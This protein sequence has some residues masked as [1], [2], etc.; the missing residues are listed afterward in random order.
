MP[1]PQCPNC[2]QP[3]NR[4]LDLAYGYWQ[5][6]DEA[7][8]YVHQTCSDRVDV[9]PWVHDQCMGELRDLHP[10]NDYSGAAT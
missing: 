3:V 1:V 9:A 6:S 8:G 2:D 4:I 10:Q 5:W 7:G